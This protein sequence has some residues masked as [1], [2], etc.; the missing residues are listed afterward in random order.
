MPA[1]KNRLNLPWT[2]A[3]TSRMRAMAKARKSAREAAKVLRRTRGAVAYK[4]M[5]LGVHF[6]NV[7]QPQG[8]QQRIQRRRAARQRA[9]A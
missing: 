8:I 3:D 6:K 4:A 9:A 2:A 5:V 1:T 7:R